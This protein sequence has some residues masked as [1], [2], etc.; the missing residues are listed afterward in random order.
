MALFA[1]GAE[2]AF[3]NVGMAVGAFLADVGED[4]LQVALGARHALVHATQRVARLRVVKLR[5]VADRFPS[6]LC[7]TILTRNVQRTVR[8]SRVATSLRLRSCGGV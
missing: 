2:L 1:I 7:M 5:D 4:W 8:A 6:T 3:V